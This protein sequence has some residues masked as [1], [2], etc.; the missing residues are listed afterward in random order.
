[1]ALEIEVCVDT[2]EA[3]LVAE[4]NGATRIELCGRLDLDGTTPDEAFI[5]AALTQLQI[6][7]HVMIRPRGGDF[8]YSEAEFAEMEQAIDRCKALGVPGVV[9]GA[10]SKSGTLDLAHILALAARA[11]PEMLVVVHKCI[12]FTPDPAA[13]FDQLLEHDDLIDYVLTSGGKPT[14]KEGLPVLQYMIKQG[15]DRIKVMAAGKITKDN[16]NELSDA[17][18]APAYHGRLIV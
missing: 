18:G 15:R 8:V 2:L 16:L 7:I 14:A 3:A 5:Q 9:L 13:A 1:M 6:P 4:A 12:D 17:L 10:L 11:K